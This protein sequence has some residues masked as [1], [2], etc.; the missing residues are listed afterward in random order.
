MARNRRS[1]KRSGTCPRS[2]AHHNQSLDGIGTGTMSTL[3]TEGK[4]SDGGLSSDRLDSEGGTYTEMTSVTGSEE[5]NSAVGALAADNDAD[6]DMSDDHST[7]APNDSEHPA[8]VDAHD[9]DEPLP[10]ERDMEM[11]ST[12]SITE[13]DLDYRWE[14]G[15]RYCGPHYH[16]P[17]DEYEQCR[18][19]LIHRIYFDIFDGELS[20]VALHDPDRILDIGTGI[21]EWAIAVSDAFPDCEVIG[22]DISAIQPTSVPAN[23]FFEIDDAELEWTREPDSFDLVHFRDMLGAF[24]DWN[25]IYQEAF[26]VI[27]PGGWIELMD[28]D[29]SSSALKAFLSSFPEESDIHRLARDLTLSTAKS[30]RPRGLQHLSPSLLHRAGFVDIKMTEHVIPINIE[31]GGGKLWLISCIDGLEASTL[32]SLTQHMGWEADEVKEACLN[33]AREMTRFARDPIKAKGLNVKI[34]SVVG[35][36]PT[37]TIPQEEQGRGEELEFVPQVVTHDMRLD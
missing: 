35:R 25:F 9:P 28:I 33:V 12:R 7:S 17:N 6:A 16:M 22:T 34:R 18:M 20:S 14:H 5:L 37:A 26:T 23:C 27:K 1:K 19:S 32:R 21:G 4:S 31:A 8:L 11:A 36:K 2:R 15:R 10:T 30:G 3:S 29:D 13:Q 24:E